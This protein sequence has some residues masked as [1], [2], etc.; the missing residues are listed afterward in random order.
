MKQWTLQGQQKRQIYLSKSR[1]EVAR[2]AGRSAASCSGLRW[3][4]FMSFTQ[5]TQ[6]TSGLLLLFSLHRPHANS[7]NEL[8]KKKNTII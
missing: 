7:C 1:H 6:V 2:E 8:K 4:L 5:N 3:P